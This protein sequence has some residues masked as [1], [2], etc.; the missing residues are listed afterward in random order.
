MWTC[1]EPA[2]RACCLPRMEEKREREREKKDGD[3][4]DDDDNDAVDAGVWS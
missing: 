3:E 1:I 4:E 2:W